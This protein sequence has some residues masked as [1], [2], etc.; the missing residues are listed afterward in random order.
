MRD[1]SSQVDRLGQMPIVQPATREVVVAVHDTGVDSGHPL[2]KS[3]LL[4]SATAIPGGDPLD[5]DGHGTAMAGLAVYGDLAQQVPSGSL[6]PAASLVTVDYLRAGETGEV[7]WAERSE[8]SVEIAEQS[9]GTHRVVHNISWGAK[10]PREHE[11]T[12]WSSAL[13]RLAW[14]DGAGRLIVVSAGNTDPSPG[15]ENYP[16]QVLASQMTQPAQAWNVITVNGVT[17]LATLSPRDEEL[18]YPAPVAASGEVSP[19]SSIGPARIAPTKPDVAAEAGNTAPDGLN[20]NTATYG[21]S[22][23]TTA[24]RKIGVTVGRT[25]ATS[26]AAAITTNLLARLWA[27][28]PELSPASIRALLAHGAEI[29]SAALSQLG[30]MDARR[31]MGHGVAVADSALYSDFGRPVLIHEGAI[32]P[33]WRGLDKRTK[34]EVAYVRLPF[35]TSSLQAIGDEL[36]ELRITLSYFVE[37]SQRYRKST[38]AG[39]RLRW[40]LQGPNESE[41]DFRARVNLLSRDNAHPGDSAST[42]QWAVGSDARSRGS[43][44]RDIVVDAAAA[45]AGERLI[46]VYPVL[47]WWNGRSGF[48]G[49]T[50]PFSL[51]ASLALTDESVDIY[52]EIQ[53]EIESEVDVDLEV[54]AD[55]EVDE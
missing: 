25:N 11:P 49:R 32:R 38:Y 44:Q 14:N 22:L 15:R 16:S 4:D 13:D 37:P 42:Y 47:G 30:S 1:Y 33:G 7:L 39:A 45:F 18:G 3:V 40:E 55:V 5:Y 53:A 12:S 41:L 34:R 19:Y 46:A 21:L 48:E 8:L 17:E 29:P 36:A 43:L 23:V 2:L 9:A 28:Y 6:K 54:G 52:S 10:N 31:A 24:R 26:A 27:Q 50:L 51:V 35:P 20:A